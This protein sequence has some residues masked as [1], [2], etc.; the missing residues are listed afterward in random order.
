MWED[1]LFEKYPELFRTKKAVGGL[2][3]VLEKRN[4]F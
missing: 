3:K 1:Y 4:G 2:I